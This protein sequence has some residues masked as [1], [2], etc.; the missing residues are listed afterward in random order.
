MT[1][2]ICPY[3]RVIESTAWEGFV[4]DRLI[5][6]TDRHFLAPQFL[7]AVRGHAYR[8]DTRDEIRYVGEGD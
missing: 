4:N 5:T 7:N 8:R 1:A 6:G 2:E 3:Q